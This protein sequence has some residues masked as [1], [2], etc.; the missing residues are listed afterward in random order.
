M[1]LDVTKLYQLLPAVY[2]VRDAELALQMGGMLEAAEVAELAEL[3]ALL[4]SQG[5]LTAQQESRLEELQDKNQTGPL[6]ALISI[7]AEQVE[8]L[9]DSLQQAYDDQ[10]I[11]TCQEWVVPYIGDLVGVTGLHDF[12]NAPFTNRAL[13][14]DTLALRQ[15]K[16][17]VCVLEELARDVTGWP[18]NV[19]EYF[20][21]L[22]TSQY[23]NHLRKTNLTVADI[24]YA[25]QQL[26]NTPFDRY[27]HSL[28][29]RNIENQRGKYNV[30]NIG[31][32][33]WRIGSNSVTKAPAYSL[34]DRRYLFDAIGR[35]TQLY[36]N[37]QTEEHITQLAGPLNVPMA[38][39]RRT[40]HDRFSDYYEA[41]PGREAKSFM[42]HFTL[43]A[44]SPPSSLKLCACD[45]SDVTDSGG[46][47]IGWA[48]QPKGVIGIDPQLGRIAFPS[49]ISPPSDVHV[50]YFYGFS[51]PMGGG[52]YDRRV[53]AGA[54]VVVKV[55]AD[56]PTIQLALD[57]AISQLSGLKTSAIVE[58][59]DNEYYIE[60]P[61][62]RVPEGTSVELQASNQ[63]RPVLVLS[64]DMVVTG[65][66][67]SA[68]SINGFLI[69]SGSIVVPE[70][71]SDGSD[72]QLRQ[73]EIE[74]CTL[75]PAATPKIKTAPAHPAGPR[76]LVEAANASLVVK[77]SIVGSIR[78]TDEV[79]V[80][81]CNSIVDAT[82]QSEVAYAAP[83][84]SGAG[85]PVTIQNS[86]IIGKVHALRTDLV[87]NTIFASE[88]AKLDDWPGPVIAEQVQQG[89]VRFSYV[90]PG[91]KVPRR[92]QCHPSDSDSGVVRPAFTSLRFGNP[93]YCQLAVQSGPE[94]LEG[95]DDQA[96]MGAFHDLFEPQ[97]EANLR[98][99]LQEY[100]RFGL[101]AGIFYSS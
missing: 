53:G 65:G 36:T 62:I 82:S 57:S 26:L 74:H 34:D 11:E 83:D 49:D 44:S 9:E 88:L 59:Q 14:A 6:K 28:E 5:T 7:L 10:F 72:N 29:V 81:L 40:L 3:S 30:P 20:Q 95:A 33:L 38:I 22:G 94:I 73:L 52:E 70:K 15:R 43:A 23:M 48:H 75:V 31:I 101:Q 67:Q 92:F 1:T 50:D 13:V 89:C 16:G 79:K 46:N 61:S 18:S 8:V 47:V 80:V 55:P 56:Q 77:Q 100:L 84:S 78:A 86:T 54:D 37:P 12:P 90:P 24:R 98:G 27:A 35:D 64:G 41:D 51:A 69:S 96:A 99:S 39:S 4:A 58:V 42:L 85:G 93:G 60:T 71:D 76:L 19:V 97:R 87:S 17:T 66:K 68:L 25:D 45:L 91:S 2:R 21:L 63:K 32:F